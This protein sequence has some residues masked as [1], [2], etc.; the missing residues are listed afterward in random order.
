MEYF[1]KEGNNIHEIM[2]VNVT[3]Q[4]AYDAQFFQ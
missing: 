1:L 3:K 4:N 2:Q